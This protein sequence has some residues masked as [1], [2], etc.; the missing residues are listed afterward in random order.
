MELYSVAIHKLP[1]RH[2]AVMLKKNKT[3]QPPP[4]KKTG[5]ITLASGKGDA[6]CYRTHQGIQSSG[7]I[8]SCSLTYYPSHLQHITSGNGLQK[9]SR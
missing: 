7:F 9:D 5:E 1:H 2:N 3:N 8:G 4:Q 6:M